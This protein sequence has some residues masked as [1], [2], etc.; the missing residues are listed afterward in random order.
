MK[1]RNGLVLKKD[2]N[3]CLLLLS[4]GEFKRVSF[5]KEVQIGEEVPVS[6]ESPALRMVLLLTTVSCYLA[7][8]SWIFCQS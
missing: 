6:P 7:Y 2:N 8:F 5:S 3:N 4:G 1:K